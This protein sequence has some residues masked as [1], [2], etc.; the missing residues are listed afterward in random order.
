MSTLPESSSQL[1]FEEGK[2]GD[3]LEMWLVHSLA[4]KHFGME[5]SELPPM[6]EAQELEVKKVLAW[7]AHALGRSCEEGCLDVDKV[8]ASVQDSKL[9]MNPYEIRYLLAPAC[10][11]ANR[12]FAK[13]RDYRKAVAKTIEM[14]A[15][16]S[17]QTETMILKLKN[18]LEQAE[19]TESELDRRTQSV[20][21]WRSQ[22][23]KQFDTELID[24]EDSAIAEV[25]IASGMILGAW[26]KLEAKKLPV[27]AAE[28]DDTPMPAIPEN[29]ELAHANNMVEDAMMLGEL[30]A[31]LEADVGNGGQ[32]LW[33]LGLLGCARNSAFLLQFLQTLHSISPLI[34]RWVEILISPNPNPK[35]T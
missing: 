6:N 20:D 21:A 24:L 28:A 1:L 3:L 23:S 13:L 35:H 27:P 4:V 5:I 12:A 18:S 22:K 11:A 33:G 31:A 19:I 8:Q 9:P 34:L 26:R 10:E 17:R 7:A 25:R 14:R 29:D 16:V 30:E 32:E 2:E 15:T